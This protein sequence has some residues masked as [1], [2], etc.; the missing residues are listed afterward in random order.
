MEVRY[1]A[2]PVRFQRITT[3]EIREN[4]LIQSL[5]K[6]GAIEMIYSDTDRAIIGSAVPFDTS[7]ILSTMDELRACIRIFR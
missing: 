2:D 7:I 3:E 6:T 4:F 5:F 1:A